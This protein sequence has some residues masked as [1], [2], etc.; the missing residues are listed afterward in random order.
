M[1]WFDSTHPRLNHRVVESDYGIAGKA[2]G[3]HML[4]WFYRYLCHFWKSEPFVDMVWGSNPW[5]LTIVET[6]KRLWHV[7]GGWYVCPSQGYVQR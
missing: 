5:Y 4:L 3:R 2:D 7:S 1:W 6:G